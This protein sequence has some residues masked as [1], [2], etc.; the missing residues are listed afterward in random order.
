MS[1]SLETH[2][3]TSQEPIR[4]VTT[5]IQGD[6]TRLSTPLMIPK[7]KIGFRGLGKFLSTI[8]FDQGYLTDVILITMINRYFGVSNIPAVYNGGF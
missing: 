5:P 8:I 2:T 4:L 1:C 3:Q 7:P 6:I